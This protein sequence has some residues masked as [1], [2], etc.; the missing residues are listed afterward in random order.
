MKDKIIVYEKLNFLAF[1]I[2]LVYRFFY[3]KQ[4]FID[5]SPFLKKGFHSIIK[6]IGLKQIHSIHNLSY[7]IMHPASIMAIKIGNKV[8]E[9]NPG[10]YVPFTKLLRDQRAV[11]LVKWLFA[12]R[13]HSET[14]NYQL[15][16]RFNES[17]SSDIYYFPTKKCFIM[18]HIAESTEKI[19]MIKWHYLLLTLTDVIK[20]FSYFLVF[21]F[22]PL[23]L[24][25]MLIKEHRI[26]LKTSNEKTRRK[27]LFVHTSNK[28][29]DASNVNIC[30]DMY[31]FHKNIIQ[32][33]DCIH[34]CTR[35]PFTHE[36]ELFLIENGGVHYNYQHQKIALYYIIK[37]LF[38]DYFRCF[39]MSFYTLA[40]YCLN[41]S[42]CRVILG[43]VY[44]MVKLENL[45]KHIDV[46]MAFIE[47]EVDYHTSILTLLAN[48]KGIKTM[49]FL[50]GY[51]AYCFAIYNR[52]NNVINYFIVPGS[53]YKKYLEP[54]NPHV[55]KFF[56]AGNHEIDKVDSGL[57]PNQNS[58][59]S[60]KILRIKKDN[61]KI[62]TV[63]AGFKKTFIP[64][65]QTKPLFDES[66]AR[67][68]F[69]KYWLPF[70]K[71]ASKQ[72]SCFFIFKGKAG[73]KQYEV[74]FIKEALGEIPR[75]KYYQDDN[76]LML[77]VINISDCVI[78][79]GNSSALYSSLCFGVPSVSY[80]PGV[81]GYVAVEKYN[82]YLVASNPDE[83]IK[84]IKYI[85]KNGLPE[86]L[87]NEVRKD[88]Y[89]EGKV[90][91]KTSFRIKKLITE[92]LQDS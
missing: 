81:T 28:L 15:L 41:F 80:D 37:R 70:F 66:N 44:S 36:K 58:S 52:A 71:W 67:N 19:I 84:N 64:A 83:L 61:K 55:D 88:H 26:V 69:F 43:S 91:G 30:R 3:H 23:I 33:K 39:F 17:V 24:L 8:V 7:S 68:A 47:S 57:I 40:M 62:V 56:A 35:N 31:L 34:S 22:T 2:S 45:L 92:V 53:Y 85:L 78:S 6:K 72:D 82:K 89:A 5:Y 60:A 73:S 46:E 63:F 14:Y 27:V 90:D 65:Y 21:A 25:M 79:S 87:F 54:N 74:D 4:Y 59:I 9:K 77:D 86:S 16:Q 42:H 29:E 75:D 13:L 50:H 48:K 20:K 12:N 11:S 1:C 38:V 10:L 76:L 18:G 49:T 51:G 32:I